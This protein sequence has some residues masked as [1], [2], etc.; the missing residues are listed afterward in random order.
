VTGTGEDLEAKQDLVAEAGAL[1]PPEE[2]WAQGCCWEYGKSEERGPG[3][4]VLSNS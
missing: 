3:S 1:G 2:E 4:Y